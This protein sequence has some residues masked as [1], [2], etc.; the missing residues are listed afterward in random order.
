MPWIQQWPI[1]ALQLSRKC[2][3]NVL[4]PCCVF[5]FSTII[6]QWKLLPC[7]ALEKQRNILAQALLWRRVWLLKEAWKHMWLG[8][9]EGPAAAAQPQSSRSAER[10]SNSQ[11]SKTIELEQQVLPSILCL[12]VC[13]CARLWASP[14]WGRLRPLFPY[15]VVFLLSD[16]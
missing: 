5:P 15:T 9:V 11:K 8:A 14:Q 4:F 7:V 1:H 12:R 3:I 13:V 2:L 16:F 10:A 6:I